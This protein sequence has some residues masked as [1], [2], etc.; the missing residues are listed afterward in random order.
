MA[1]LSNLTAIH[2]HAVYPQSSVITYL[3]DVQLET[4]QR[5]GSLSTDQ[6]SATWIERCNCPKGYV[7]QFCESCAPGFR[8]VSDAIQA[9]S[10]ALTHKRA[11]KSFET[12]VPCVCNGHAD[13]CDSETGQCICQ[14]NTMGENCDQCARGYYGNARLGDF[15]ELG[16]NVLK[17]NR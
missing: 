11:S 12:C 17:I 1:I 6:L 7:G 13:I 4:A 16:V 8:H 10:L 2:I 14:H 3:D 9:T 5:T 15:L